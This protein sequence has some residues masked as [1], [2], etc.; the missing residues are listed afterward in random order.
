MLV[1]EAEVQLDSSMFVMLARSTTQIGARQGN[2]EMTYL[3]RRARGTAVPVQAT[4][5]GRVS[6]DTVLPP[7]A[8]DGL[9]LYPVL[10]SQHWEVGD[11]D[12]L[13]IFDTDELSIT[14][15]VL[16]VIGLEGIAFGAAQTPALRAEL[17]STQ[18]PVTLW[19]TE[20]RPH[21]LLKVA[22]AS[23]ESILVP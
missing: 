21:R 7:G 14:R 12:T 9:A 22:S 10:L 23:G 8:F 2:S 1:Q 11:V 19:F 3:G 20:S 15:Q 18:L 5:P 17:S 13:T 4:V 16:R 6:I